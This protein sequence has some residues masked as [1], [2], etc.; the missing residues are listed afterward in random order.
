[1]VQK[2]N[3][4]I[5]F[6]KIDYFNIADF[7]LLEKWHNSKLYKNTYSWNPSQEDYLSYLPKE[8]IKKKYLKD[9]DINDH[10]F[11]LAD[12]NPIGEAYLA[13]NPKSLFKRENS[14]A[15]NFH[16]LCEEAKNE[17]KMIKIQTV[18][19]FEKCAQDAGAQT[20]EVNAFEH[21]YQGVIFYKDLGYKEV[22]RIAQWT[23]KAGRMW[24]DIRLHKSLAVNGR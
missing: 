20:M 7:I 3:A 12:E 1:M 10:Y 21:D 22:G 9:K 13:L 15:F 23:F 11:I 24:G 18:R 14:T 16:Y 6:R 2:R 17:V 8:I 19:Y 5:S 4:Q